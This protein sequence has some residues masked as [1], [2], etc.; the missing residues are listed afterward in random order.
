MGA[1]GGGRPAASLPFNADA[2]VLLSA[3]I[4]RS[5]TRLAVCDLAGEIRATTDIDQD[6]GLGPDDLMPDVVKRLDAL[7]D[8]SGHRNE[9]IY[10]I[11]LSLPGTVD[12]ER[13]CSLD[14][15]IMTGREGVPLP[16]YFAELTHTPVILDNDANVTA[17]A[18]ARDARQAFHVAAGT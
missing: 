12:R 14:S 9:K 2:G 8:E 5:R 11:G 1:W 7:L 4:G 13:G 6:P 18:E 3:A 16:P 17:L 15:P 10:G